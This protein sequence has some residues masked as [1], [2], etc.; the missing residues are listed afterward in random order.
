MSGSESRTLDARCHCGQVHLRAV[1]RPIVSTACYCE[2]C[3]KAG[4]LFEALPG[5]GRVSNS[6]GSTDYVLFRKDRIACAKGADRLGEHRLTATSKTRRVVATCCNAPM[7]LEFTGGHWLTLYRDRFDPSARP[8]VEMRVMTRDRRE[9]ITIA[10]DLPNHKGHSG[11]F[12]LK[13][14]GAWAA[15]AFRAPKVDYVKGA[16]DGHGT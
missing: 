6:D 5:A 9:G 3:R 2:S 10:P 13:L 16:L 4:A 15:M 8:P 12:M 11:R 1:G 7:F 14:I